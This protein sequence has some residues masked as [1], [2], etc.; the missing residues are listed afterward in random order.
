MLFGYDFIFL[1]S[2]NKVK[3]WEPQWH[4]HEFWISLPLYN[5][6]L[7]GDQLKIWFHLR[8]HVVRFIQKRHECHERF[9]SPKI[10]WKVL[11]RSSKGFHQSSAPRLWFY[12]HTSAAIISNTKKFHHFQIFPTELYLSYISCSFFS[13][14]NHIYELKLK[15]KNM[16]WRNWVCIQKARLWNFTNPVSLLKKNK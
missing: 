12:T 11:L 4:T 3:I 9:C 8:I 6:V 14:F 10:R 13:N 2:M 16:W 1:Q 15:K 7:M 5:P